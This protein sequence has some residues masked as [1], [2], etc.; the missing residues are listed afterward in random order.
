MESL[1][2]EIQEATRPIAPSPEMGEK[3]KKL[4]PYYEK[5]KSAFGRSFVDDFCDLDAET[6]RL[7]IDEAFSRG[8][9]TGAQLMLEV[10]SR[11]SS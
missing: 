3:T 7:E 5:I 4:D 6:W 8:F 2:K 10:L 9:R 1:I 11:Y